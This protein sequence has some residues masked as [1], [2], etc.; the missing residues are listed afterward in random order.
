[1]ILYKV[2]YFYLCGQNDFSK[3]FMR[4]RNE[5]GIIVSTTKILDSKYPKEYETIVNNNYDN[6]I[7]TYRSLKV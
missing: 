6:I 2:A 7:L 3:E 4:V 1:M 5:N